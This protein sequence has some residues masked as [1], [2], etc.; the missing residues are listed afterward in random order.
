MSYDLEVWSA[1]EVAIPAALPAPEKWVIQD[2][3][4]TYSGKGWQ[5]VVDNPIS[6]DAEDLPEQVGSLLPGIAYLTR[7]ALEPGGVSRTAHQLLMRS[8]R[9]LAKAGHGVIYDPQNDVAALGAGVKKFAPPGKERQVENLI[10]SWWFGPDALA[11]RADY[12]EL[13]ALLRKHLP[14]ALPRRYGTCEPP[15]YR[16]SDTGEE[17]LINFL[18]NEGRESMAVL[19][20]HR[21]VTSFTIHLPEQFGQTP[22]WLGFRANMISIQISAATLQQPG[23]ERQIRRFWRAVSEFLQPFYGDV[24]YVSGVQPHPVRAWFWRGFPSTSGV[25]AVIGPPYLDLWPQCAEARK[26]GDSLAYLSGERWREAADIFHDIGG[27]P[28]ELC[29]PNANYWSIE[30]YP[31]GWPF[32]LP[33]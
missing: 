27:V 1:E 8:A 31:P 23:W 10:L 19:F 20:P 16:L 14:E 12:R 3:I 4:S 28:A 26:R 18:A 9:S 22:G 32:D 30:H 11:T 29:N 24:R 6:V 5:V 21:P 33:A 7:I 17:H 2:G 15:E 25:A 13:V